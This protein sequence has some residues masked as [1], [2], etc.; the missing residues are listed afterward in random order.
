MNTIDFEV[1]K[2]CSVTCHVL[3]SNI[4]RCNCDIENNIQ[5]KKS[6]DPDDIVKNGYFGLHWI[7]MVEHSSV[8]MVSIYVYPAAPFD[9]IT[10]C[11]EGTLL[12]AF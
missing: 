3:C 2:F 11:L 4:S 7:L 1:S 10:F 9:I 8:P 5:S 12:E 6:E